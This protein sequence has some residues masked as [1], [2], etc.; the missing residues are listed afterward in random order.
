MLTITQPAHMVT[1]VSVLGLAYLLSPRNHEMGFKSPLLS[2][3]YLASFA[4]HFGAQMWM[5][6]VSGKKQM[7]K[8]GLLLF[9]SIPR[10]SFGQVQRVL[11]P[12]YFL[13]NSILSF[14]TL[15]LFV[16]FQPFGQLSTRW[17]S[18]QVG[19]QV[20]C[21]LVELGTRLYL[22][23]PL[24]AALSQKLVMEKAARIGQEVGHY[25]L[26]RLKN[27]PHFM[28]LHRQFRR[29]HIVIALG[30]MV[31]MACTSFHLYHL[32]S[33]LCYRFHQAAVP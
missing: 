9:F 12:T 23:P 19:S 4:F 28:K 17:D 8:S 27:C 22:T 5:T 20:V 10:H 13:I 7:A 11:F 3:L 25:N 15:T 32:A 33:Q 16:H 14:I 18:M 6:F 1:F 24:L 29:I 26:G 31:A 30:N 2:F 21:F